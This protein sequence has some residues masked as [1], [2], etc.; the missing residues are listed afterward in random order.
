MKKLLIG[1]G[2]QLGS[3]AV[4]IIVAALILPGFQLRFSGFLTAVI[5]FTI[6][7]SLLENLASRLGQ[8]FAPAWVG[9]ASLVST[10]FALV[11]ANLFRDGTSIRGFFTWILATVIVWGITA[12]CGVLIPKYVLKEKTETAQ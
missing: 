2:V 4:A 7:Q 1:I 8:K 10:F 9:L 11:I 12:L 6:A 3:S 5:V